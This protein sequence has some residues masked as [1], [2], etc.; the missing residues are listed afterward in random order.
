MRSAIHALSLTLVALLGAPVATARPI[1]YANSA[2]AIADYTQDRMFEAQLFY[3]PK[4]YLSVG[5]GHMEIEGGGAILEHKVTYFRANFLAKRWNMEAAQANVFVWGGVDRAH[6]TQLVSLTEPPG[7][8][9]HGH[10]EP[11]PPAESSYPRSIGATGWNAGGQI[12]FET[13]RFYSSF[14][15]DSHRSSAFT[16]RI[17]TVQFGFAPY[18][19]DVN[20]L[21]TWFV[22][23]GTRYSGNAAESHDNDQLSFLLRFFKKRTWIEAGATTDGKIQARAMF[24]L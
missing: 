9:G 22:V 8:S 10:G 21:A 3:A 12:D 1:V 20:T 5:A 13:R 16:H 7:Y 18:A 14:K 19:H 6:I 24:S 11:A 2:T 23:A 4:S 17:D 15:T